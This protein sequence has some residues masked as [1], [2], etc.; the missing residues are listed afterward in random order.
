MRIAVTAHL[1]SLGSRVRAIAAAHEAVGRY[2][3]A[4]I[5]SPSTTEYQRMRRR[6]NKA[7]YDDITIDTADLTADLAHDRHRAVCTRRGRYLVT[8]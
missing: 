1:L 5:T 7:K 2:A 6:R 3:E 4:L 8:Q